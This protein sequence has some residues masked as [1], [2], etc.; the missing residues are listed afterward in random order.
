MG[1]FKRVISS[2]FDPHGRGSKGMMIADVMGKGEVL[3]AEYVTVPYTL[4]AVSADKH[5][6]EISTENVSIE[7]R[8]SKGKIIKEAGELR[9]VVALKYKSDFDGNMQIKF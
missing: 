8:V 1:G 3:F 4:A 9:A 7:S 5:V 6:T 2:L